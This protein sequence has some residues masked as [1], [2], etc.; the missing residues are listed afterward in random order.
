MSKIIYI[1]RGDPGSGK[2]TL[3]S[4]L[5][6]EH[7]FASDMFHTDDEGNFKYDVSKIEESHRWCEQTVWDAMATDKT[8]IAVHN[9]FTQGWE[10]KRYFELAKQYG[11]K[12]FVVECQNNFG[13]IHNVPA[14][15][16]I[17][18]MR[19]RHSNLDYRR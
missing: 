4:V 3:A 2:S 14:D 7:N 5:A 9:T 6:P 15:T 18:M 12:V 13:S 8:P 16:I 10:A 1:V 17:K 11:Y 19:R